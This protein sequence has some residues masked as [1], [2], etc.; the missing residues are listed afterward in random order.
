MLSL[1][2]LL[3]MVV[4]TAYAHVLPASAIAATT[5]QAVL[6]TEQTTTPS[7]AHKLVAALPILF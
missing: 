1:V 3:V 2:L 6:F 4:V 7:D 5:P